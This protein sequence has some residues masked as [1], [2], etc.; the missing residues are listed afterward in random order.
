MDYTDI[1]KPLLPRL[2]R[3]FGYPLFLLSISVVLGYGIAQAM[4]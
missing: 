1:K 2:I 3:G 4:Y